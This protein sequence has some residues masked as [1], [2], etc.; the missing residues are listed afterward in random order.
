MEDPQH[1]LL[2]MVLML[3]GHSFMP[4]VSWIPLKYLCIQSLRESLRNSD[5]SSRPKYN[6]MSL[7]IMNTFMEAKITGRPQL[8][9]SCEIK[10]IESLTYGGASS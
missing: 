8:Q 2:T 4:S 6:I 3:A 1:A 7:D 10:Q 9:P 5:R